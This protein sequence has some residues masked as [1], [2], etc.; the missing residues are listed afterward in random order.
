MN[1]VGNN[2]IGTRMRTF[3]TSQRGHLL[4]TLVFSDALSICATFLL[5]Y[6]LRFLN[7]LWPYYSPQDP[8]FY[9]RLGV[10]MVPLWLVLFA[11]HRLYDPEELLGGTREYANVISATTTGSVAILAYDF[12]MRGETLSVSRGWLL[13]AWLLA[14]P[15]VGGARFLLRRI[16]YALRRRGHLLVPALVVGANAEGHAIAEQLD[17]A[18]A[19]SGV[20][21]VGFV[22]DDPP[23]NLIQMAGPPLLGAVEDLPWLIREHGVHELIVAGTALPREQLLD[24]F[25]QFSHNGGDVTVRLS[26]GLFEILTTGMRV[27]KVAYVPLVTLERTRITGVD[28]ILKRALDL[29]GSLLALLLTSPLM[30]LIALLLKATSPGPVFYRRRVI[31]QGRVTFDAL[32]FRTMYTDGDQIL[33]RSPHLKEELRRNGK[34]KEDPRVT[35][36]GRVLRRFSL[37]ELPQFFNILV[38][39]MS[40]VGPRMITLEEWPNYGKWQHNLLTV[41]PGLTGL[42]QVSGRSDLS[43]EDRVRLDMHYIRNYTLWLDLQIILQ[44]VPVAL[45]GRG[46]Y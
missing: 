40:L 29:G 22:D 19:A 1:V 25:R 3:T 4:A 16:I 27:R 13:L 34:L 18:P 7:P 9:L 45:R 32:K 8:A 35:P 37:D 46:A 23:P 38:G 5:A 28:A 44:T 11:I 20:R 31:G 26:S 41:K 33:A 43:Y 36:L 2:L 30:V 39:Q 24:L 21:I 14:I 10:V 6:V 15:V 12:L 42:W 17:S